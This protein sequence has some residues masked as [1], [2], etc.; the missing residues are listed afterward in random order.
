MPCLCKFFQALNALKILDIDQHIY[1]RMGSGLKFS[2]T[3]EYKN[4]MLTT[5]ETVLG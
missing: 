5:Y 3:K 4:E 2:A 1:Q